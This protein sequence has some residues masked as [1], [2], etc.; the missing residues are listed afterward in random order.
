MQN[1]IIEQTT[2][3]ERIV[4]LGWNNQKKLQMS[5]QQQKG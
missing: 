1:E 3:C 5:M 2:V 4:A